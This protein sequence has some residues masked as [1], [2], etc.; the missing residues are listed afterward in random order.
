[1]IQIMK[2]PTEQGETTAPSGTVPT[3]LEAIVRLRCLEVVYNRG[4]VVL[5]PHIL[6]TRHGELHVDAVA[7]ERD[8]KV[9]REIKLGT[10]RVSGLGDVKLVDRGFVPVGLFDP[11]A[12]KYGDA[13]LMAVD[14]V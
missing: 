1:M 8:G 10:Y 5:A 2:T 14:R 6:Y 7:L 11:L 13:T 3:I 4:R 12:D 9:P